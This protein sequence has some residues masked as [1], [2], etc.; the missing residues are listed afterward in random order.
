[1]AFTGSAVVE[2]IA[3]SIVRITG[4]SLASGASGTIG[5]NQY[6]GSSGAAD[7]EL[8]AGFQPSNYD[9]V[10]LQDQVMVNSNPITSVATAIPVRVVKTGTKP[11]DFLITMT[12]DHGSLASPQLEIY[13]EIPS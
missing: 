8:P 12:N 4:V 10:S 11:L 1:M 3:D 2:Q 9:S 5:L 13:V 7:I 6:G